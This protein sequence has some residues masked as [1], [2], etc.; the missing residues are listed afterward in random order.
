MTIQPPVSPDL[1]LVK[2]RQQQAWSTGDIPI[3]ARPLVG[4]AENLCEAVELHSSQK[5]LDVAT[6]TGNVALAAARRYCEVTGIDYTPSVLEYARKRAEI[7][8]LSIT[9]LEADAEHIPFPSASFDVVLSVLGVMF[10]PNQEQAAS[11]IL[12]VCRPGGKIGL[13]NWTP[14]GF[15]RDIGQIMA[16]Y[17]PPPLGLKPPALWGSEDYLLQLFGEGIASIQT[18]KR[19]FFHRYRSIEHAVSVTCNDFG[20]AVT[21]L[22]SLEPEAR[23]RLTQDIRGMFERANKVSDGSVMVPAEYLE[24][25]AVRQ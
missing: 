25:V 2:V 1:S 10:T 20:P 3:I 16:A 8:R 22:Q 19:Y 21:A 17:A 12:R 14:D 7:E 18:T 11:E 5:V 23:V 15:F 6:C 13:A 4:V 24:V 9:F